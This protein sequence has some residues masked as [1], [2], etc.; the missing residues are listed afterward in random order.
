LHGKVLY[1]IW[2]TVKASQPNTCA[3]GN[4]RSGNLTSSVT[5]KRLTVAPHHLA[6]GLLVLLRMT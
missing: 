6:T 4:N 2:T 1:S 3:G 5:V